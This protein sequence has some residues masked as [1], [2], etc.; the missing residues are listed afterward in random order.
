[1]NY[2]KRGNNGVVLKTETGIKMINGGIKK[3]LN[4]LCLINL[5]TFDGRKKAI[6]KLLKAKKNLPIYINQQ[7]FVYPTK[8]LREYDVVFINYHHVLSWKEITPTHTKIIFNNLEE[9]IVEISSKRVKKQHQRIAYILE[10]LEE[11]S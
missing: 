11:H 8:A 10:Y 9:L 3:Y 6:S 4:D 1:M 7:V 5:A 2:L